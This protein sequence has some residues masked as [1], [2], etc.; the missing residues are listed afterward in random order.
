MKIVMP[1]NSAQL[2]EIIPVLKIYYEAKDWLGNDDYKE[3]LKA[4]IGADQYQSSYTKKAQIPQ[5]FGF[6]EWQDN[7]PRSLRRITKSGKTFYEAVL[8]DNKDQIIDSIMTSLETTTFGRDNCGC[9][10]SESDVE[11]PVVFLRGIIDL[12]Y[13]TYQEFA[14]LLFRMEDGG[15]T[16]TDAINEIKAA[17]ASNSFVLPEEAVKYTDAKPI[18]FLERLG[19]LS[20]ITSDGNAKRIGFSE[21]V[22]NRY[23]DRI[24]NLPIYNIDK[25]NVVNNENSLLNDYKKL[26]DAI[27]LE[28]QAFAETIM[29]IAEKYQVL[30]DEDIAL[31]VNYP[32]CHDMFSSEL[33]IIRETG[34]SE[35][36]LR[37]TATESS[38][39]RYYINRYYMLNGRT[40]IVT[41]H[42]YRE[43]SS[44]NNNRTP[45]FN[46]FLQRFEE[47]FPEITVDLS[48]KSE[49]IDN[50]YAYMRSRGYKYDKK[51]VQDFYLSL[52]SK[53][54]VILAGT[55]GTGKSKFVELFAGAIGCN[56]I[57][58][59]SN[60]RLLIEAVRPDWSD[61]S[62]LLGY[63][64]LQG[65]YQKTRIA[66]FIVNAMNNPK[67]P[68]ILCLDEMNL[69][70]VEYYF[71]DFL[72]KM[73]TRHKDNGLIKTENLAR[74]AIGENG[75][76]LDLYIP[77]NFYIVGTVNM[78]ETTFQFSKKVLDRANTIEF[79]IDTTEN[80]TIKPDFSASELVDPKILPNLFLKPDYLNLEKDCRSTD[81]DY[82]DTICEDLDTINRILGKANLEFAYRIRDDIVFYML[83]AN[84]FNLFTDQNGNKTN[85]A[86]DFCIM[87]KILPRIQGSGSDIQKVLEE[88][89]KF[90]HDNSYKRSE[91]KVIFMKDRL[92]DDSYTSYWR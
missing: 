18:M 41:N 36:E 44:K 77:E 21:T 81:Y 92:K 66:Q 43:D 47:K 37:E 84:E 27:S 87:Q 10:E 12:K 39:L 60:G 17:R 7:N 23:L 59:D 64:N 90:F 69:A 82:V 30:S 45:F 46:W 31:L 28:N 13:L 15:A 8:S 19:F 25:K 1:K 74:V 34:I 20:A 63:N 2:D 50:I 83:Y 67:M 88:L 55:S 9:P 26:L 62:D 4:I 3:Q 35:E 6:V 61:S 11:P 68:Y 5:Y 38:R 54:F 22:R 53:P 73:E 16:Y 79:A 42:W 33:E 76:A 91:N 57:N 78:D 89:E 48:N 14:F 56:S 72:S 40:F 86:M 51:L 32:K 65:K 24:R 80:G 29:Q 85:D 49:L 52:R 75:E 71:S 58:D 70:R